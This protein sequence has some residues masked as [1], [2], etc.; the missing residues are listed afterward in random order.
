[1]GAQID[2]RRMQR[3]SRE[4]FFKAIRNELA[5]LRNTEAFQERLAARKQKALTGW[6]SQKP[7]RIGRI[8]LTIPKGF[9]QEMRPPHQGG[10]HDSDL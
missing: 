4:E 2:L 1:M 6:S 5:S 8:N 7:S 10:Q 9:C 3:E